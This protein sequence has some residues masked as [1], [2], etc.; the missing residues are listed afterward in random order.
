M[1][2]NGISSKKLTIL[3]LIPII[4]L[5]LTLTA[6]ANQ[7]DY[8][9]KSITLLIPFSAGGSGDTISR[10]VAMI[11]EKYLGQ[12]VICKNVTGGSGAICINQMLSRPADGYTIMNHSTTM[13]FV[14]ASGALEVD[15]DKIQTIC[16]VSGSAQT[17]IARDEF[18]CD[19]WD[20]FVE[21]AKDHEIKVG[22]S[23][24]NGSNH[25][26]YLKVLD[27]TGLQNTIYIPY[28]G[29]SDTMLSLI[30]E[31]VD[32]AVLSLEP[33][34]QWVESGD[35]K[36]LAVSGDKRNPSF[37]DV[38]TFK[39]LGIDGLENELIWRG[40]FCKA[41]TPQYAIDK[42][43]EV[44]EKVLQ[45]PQWEKFIET[46]GDDTMFRNSEQLKKMFLEKLED[47]KKYFVKP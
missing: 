44:W 11:A 31:N 34:A 36:L 47:G 30:G 4:F 2:I 37:P 3:I 9:T 21:Y 1:K 12:S 28:N 42:I 24:I 23:H 32:V 16:T 45:D 38:P 39:E 17:F 43:A 33:P 19:T 5:V 35:A 20:E 22:G 8:P 29:G 13:P 26:F 6:F 14:I 15:I 7:S 40:Y 46:S 41:G 18:P 10:Q 27:K 25:L